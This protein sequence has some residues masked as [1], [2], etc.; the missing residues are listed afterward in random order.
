MEIYKDEERLDFE[1]VSITRFENKLFELGQEFYN[2][3]LN[4]NSIKQLKGDKDILEK[5]FLH[6]FVEEINL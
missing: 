6:Q 5:A 4:F 1:N 3:E 2:T